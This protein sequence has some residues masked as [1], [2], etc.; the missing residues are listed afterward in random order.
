MMKPV[1]SDPKLGLAAGLGRELAY[2]DLVCID[3]ELTVVWQC[4]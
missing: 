1:V 3:N 2:D 4:S